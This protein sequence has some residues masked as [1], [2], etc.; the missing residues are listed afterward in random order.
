MTVKPSFNAPHLMRGLLKVEPFAV[1]D[2]I[3]DLLCLFRKGPG[4]GPGQRPNVDLPIVNQTAPQS[5]YGV[6]HLY[7]GLQFKHS[8]I[9]RCSFEPAKTGSPASAGQRRHSHRKIQNPKAGLLRG[10]RNLARSFSAG[11][12]VETLEA[13]LEKCTDRQTKPDV[14]RFGYGSFFS[15]TLALLFSALPALGAPTPGSDWDWQLSG[16]VAPPEGVRVFATD[17]DN[18]TKEQIAALNADGVYTICYV[19]VG[20][21]ENYRD[22]VDHFPPTI[23]G[24]RYED[25]PDENFLDIRDRNHLPALMA[26]RFSRC[27]MMG[28]DAV[29]PDNMDVFDNDSGFPLT[30]EDGLNYIK[31]LATT[32]HMLGLEIG[33][34][35]APDLTNDLVRTM[36]FAIT[37]SCYQDEW[38]TQVLPYVRYGKPVFDAEY[39]D[40][41]ID[42]ENACRRAQKSLISVILK[43]RDLGPARQS[44]R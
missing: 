29:E 10:L 15:V 2:L 43:D 22:D 12:K 16:T 21:L 11:T 19:S 8:D 9:H 28:F 7:H 35:N 20:T 42:F 13:R 44:C 27:K 34:K 24:N 39:T 14:G 4:S 6:L 36:D 26:E 41:E 31:L 32:A 3:R 37:E 38:C 5:R 33:Q 30:R 17:P 40:R 18:V 25:W 1:P 23:V